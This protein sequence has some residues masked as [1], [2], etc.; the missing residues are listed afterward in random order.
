MLAPPRFSA[1]NTRVP[2]GAFQNALLASRALVVIA[3]SLLAQGCSQENNSAGTGG[4]TGMT[5]TGGATTDNGTG[6]SLS[7][8]TGGATNGTGGASVG[9]SGGS[10]GTSGGSS[11]SSGTGGASDGSG[12]SGATGGGGSTPVGVACTTQAKGGAC[13]TPT[14]SCAKTCGPKNATNV[15]TG[16]KT[17]TCAAAAYVEGACAFPAGDYTCFKVTAATAACPAATAANGACAITS[18]MPCSGY[19]DSTGAAKIGFCHCVNSK[20]SCGSA[21]EWPCQ[22]TG[23][24]TSP[25]GTGC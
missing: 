7:M 19:A 18:C 4:T 23:V 25:G 8:G 6:G 13:L 14:D 17:E 20:W 3:L 2:R 1:S 24:S 21:K 10:S 15:S 5:G 11:A 22:A 16:A 12:G 9:T